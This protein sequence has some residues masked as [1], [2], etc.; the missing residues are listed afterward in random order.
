M[1]KENVIAKDID[2]ILLL[3]LYIIKCPDPIFQKAQTEKSRKHFRF[4]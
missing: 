4:H 2:P 1:T 3:I